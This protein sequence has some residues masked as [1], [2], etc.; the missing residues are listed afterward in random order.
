[1]TP[2]KIVVS[3]VMSLEGGGGPE[4]GSQRKKNVNLKCLEQ[5]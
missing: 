2:S 5:V 4:S 3:I 1:M